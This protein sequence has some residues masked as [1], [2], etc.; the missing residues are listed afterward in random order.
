MKHILEYA[1]FSDFATSRD[2]QIKKKLEE[3]GI[4]KKDAR[5]ISRLFFEKYNKEAYIS[6]NDKKTHPFLDRIKN[7]TNFKSITEFNEFINNVFKELVYNNF[8]KIDEIKGYVKYGLSF[9]NRN[10]YLIISID[11][12]NFFSNYAL[13]HINSIA[14]TTPDVYKTI[15]INDDN[16]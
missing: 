16:F 11:H 15:N 4:F 2:P 5:L 14:I 9:N 10:F 13:V 3:E 6:W 12:K 8:N 1:R 7:R